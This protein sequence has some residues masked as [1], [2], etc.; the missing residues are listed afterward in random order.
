[1]RFFITGGTGSLGTAFLEYARQ[2]AHRVTIYSRDEVKQGQLRVRYPEAEFVLGD[3]R[4]ED[5]M[6]MRMAKHDV[7]I[8]AAAYKQVPAAE[9]N[10]SQAVSVNVLGSLSVARAAVRAG[11]RQVI[12]ISTDKAC[13]PVNCYGATKML[14]E[15]IFQEANGWGETRFNLVRYGNVLGSRGSVVPFFRAQAETGVLTLTNPDMTRFW[16]TLD[17]ALEIVLNAM[18]VARG[19]VLIPKCKSSTMLDL[20]FAIAPEASFKVIGTRPGEKLHEQLINAAESMHTVDL[21]DYFCIYPATEIPE[22]H[23]ENGFEYTSYGAP[24]LTVEKLQELLKYA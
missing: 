10:S 19:T 16:M 5:W 9:V 6:A 20:A 21:G 15:K 1:M 2:F 17:D 3:V 11:I 12:G 8:H 13:A 23:L 7:V 24:R 14:M 4:D 18:D 22:G